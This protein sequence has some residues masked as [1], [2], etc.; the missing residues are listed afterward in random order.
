MKRFVARHWFLLLT[1]AG[2]AAVWQWPG[3]VRW[4]C[5]VDHTA[6]G[7][8]VIFLSALGLPGHRLAGA[9]G[10]PLPALGGLAISYG[11]LPALAWQAGRLLPLEDFR[12]GLLLVASVPC[13]LASA[14]IWTR[15]AGGDDATALL[16]TLLTNATGWLATTAWLALAAGEGTGAGPALPMMLRLI[17]VLVLP[18]ALGQLARAAGPVARAAARHQT[19][20]SVLTRLLV[21]AMMLKAALGVRDR[22]AGGPAGVTAGL[23][24]AV[25]AVCVGL[26]LAGL[27]GGLWGGRCLGFDRPRRIAVGIAGSQKTLPVSLMLFEAHFAGYP[28]AGVPM[29]LYHFGQLIADTLL[30]GWLRN[31]E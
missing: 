30:A 21:L 4:T 13:T 12:I 15:L 19:G 14:V 28:L 7:M 31:R 2:A 10:R 6:G 3:A 22:L 23:L 26:H 25:A 20:L 16:I 9:A 8:L 11:L 5:R 29:V 18:V 17:V 27:A 24:L 1:L